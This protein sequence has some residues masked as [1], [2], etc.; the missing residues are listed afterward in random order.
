MIRVH[1]Q[2]GTLEWEAWRREGLGASDAR[3]I[4]GEPHFP[5][6]SIYRLFREKARGISAW[7]TNFAMRRGS[8]LE[9][10][11]RAAYEQRSRCRVEVFCAQHASV[12]WL[13]ASLDGYCTSPGLPPWLIEI[14]CPRWQDHEL[15]LEGIVPEHYRPQVQHAM[16]VADVERLDYVSFS[17][18]DKFGADDRLAIV[19][20]IAPDPEW[21]AGYLERAER[22]WELVE[23]YK[24]RRQT[25][26]TAR[27]PVAARTRSPADLDYW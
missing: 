14:K 18:G 9:P 11:A 7:R 21:L 8:R 1:L 4:V 26:R 15:A 25:R 6:E 13:R 10:F 20:N 2:Q 16:F 5:D 23:A 3:L 19:P 24:L 27:V 17:D 22:F 12:P